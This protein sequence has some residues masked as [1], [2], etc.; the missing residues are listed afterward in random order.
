MSINRSGETTIELAIDYRKSFFHVNLNFVD[1]IM[2][3]LEDFCH[4][5]KMP[6]KNNT[7]I[8]KIC[9]LQV[10]CKIHNQFDIG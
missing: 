5:Y 2:F 6:N 7:I 9:Q 1:N 3:L 8:T 10:T 4:W